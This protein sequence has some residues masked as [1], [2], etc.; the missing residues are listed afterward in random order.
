MRLKPATMLSCSGAEE[1]VI[2]IAEARR[3]MSG[4]SSDPLALTGVV[5]RTVQRPQ[6][7]PYSQNAQ[8][9]QHTQQAQHAAP[10]GR[11]V[12]A[13]ELRSMSVGSAMR[14]AS[15]AHVRPRHPA[16][17]DATHQAQLCWVNV[18]LPLI[19]WPGLRCHSICCR[20]AATG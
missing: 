5:H 11:T 1:P 20:D 4:A 7:V 10:I 2:S 15:G 8:Y 16:F 17:Y 6:H 3:T 14:M 19:P 18:L 13:A 12:S 9:L